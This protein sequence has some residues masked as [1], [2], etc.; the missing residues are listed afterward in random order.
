MFFKILQHVLL[1]SSVLL[2]EDERGTLGLTFDLPR[3]PLLMLNPVLL[4]A[5]EG[6][7]AGGNL[8]VTF[9]SQSLHPD[10]QV[11]KSLV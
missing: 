9:T 2:G 8:D 1:S 11:K 10:A 7:L 6:P 4:L 5:F 3:S